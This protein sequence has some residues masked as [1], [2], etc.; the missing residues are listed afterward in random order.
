[1]STKDKDDSTDNW[2]CPHCGNPCAMIVEDAVLED[3]WR[4]ILCSCTQCYGMYIRRYKYVETIKL[5][6][7][8]ENKAT[9]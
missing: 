8:S 1:M 4:E 3:D 6:R 9:M 7:Q 5:V 2:E